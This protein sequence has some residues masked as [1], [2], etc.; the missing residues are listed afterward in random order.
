MYFKV[1]DAGNISKNETNKLN[2]VILGYKII[3][4]VMKCNSK[5]SLSLKVC[6]F[7][8]IAFVW[9]E[10]SCEFS[11]IFQ[12]GYFLEYVLAISSEFS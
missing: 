7:A 1:K 8:K 12:N 3:F 10:Y 5:G 9:G 6:N 4:S 11:N 2:L